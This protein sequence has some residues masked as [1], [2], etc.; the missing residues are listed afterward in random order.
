MAAEQGMFAGS[1][2]LSTV[3]GSH[4]DGT[5]PRRAFRRSCDRCHAQKIKCTGNQS[6][7]ARGPCQRCQQAG[8]GCVYSERCPKRKLRKASAANLVPANPK[9][10]SSPLVSSHTLPR[11]VSGSQSAPTS[12]P[13]L[14]PSGDYDWFWPSIDVDETIDTSFLELS[15]DNETISSQLEPPMLDLSSFLEFPVK[16]SP[17]PPGSSNAAGATSAHR[18]HFDGLLAVSQELEEI[19]SAVTAEWPKKEIWTYPIGMFFN[20]SRRLLARLRQQAHI[21]GNS[22]MLEECLQTKNLFMAVH[23]YMLTAK[24]LASISDLLLFHIQ[25]AQ[26]DPL[27]PLGRNRSQSPRRDASDKGSSSS[28]SSSNSSDHSR[29]DTMPLF[30]S[31][32]PIGQL[33]SY[34]NPFMHTLFSACTTLRIGLDLLRENEL[35]L[36]VPPVQGIAASITVGGGWEHEMDAARPETAHSVVGGEKLCTPASR[37]LTMFWSDEAVIHGAESAGSRGR[38]LAVLQRCYGEIFSLARQHKMAF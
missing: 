13:F 5:L 14:D 17:S 9:H 12:L 34:V 21:E 7:L 2:A 31:N 33:F 20:A 25:H 11:D 10:M 22:D 6:G 23:C 29:A 38:I 16:E 8:L 27:T 4:T 32:L 35:T 26:N 37:V 15:H 3:Q 28:N 36:G 24:I 18:E 30:T 19:L 1:V